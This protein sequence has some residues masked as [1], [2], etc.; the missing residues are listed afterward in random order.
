MFHLAFNPSIATNDALGMSTQSINQKSNNAQEGF[1]FLP[2]VIDDTFPVYSGLFNEVISS[3]M[4][5]FKSAPIEQAVGGA[6]QAEE[7]KNEDFVVLSG[8]QGEE[9]AVK[10]RELPTGLD[11]ALLIT[12][13][14][15]KKE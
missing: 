13:T 6:S 12:I 2:S 8:A 1:D 7:S 5:R 3:S 10:S 14:Q 4:A 11:E 9:S 15:V